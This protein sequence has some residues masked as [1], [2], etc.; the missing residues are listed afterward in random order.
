MLVKTLSGLFA[1]SICLAQ[2]DPALS[3]GP[4]HN[5]Q[6]P[7]SIEVLVELPNNG[8]AEAQEFQLIEDG[9]LTSRGASA[10]PFRNS[11]WKLALVLALDVSRSL[12]TKEFDEVK[13]ATI[14]FITQ[15]KDPVALISFGD[16]ADTLATFDTP[17]ESLTGV[18]SQLHPIGNRTRLY[19]ALDTCM[20]QLENRP[21]PERQRIIVISDGAEDSRAGPDSID[22]VIAKAEKHRVAIDTIWVPTAAAGARNTL[23]RISERTDGYHVDALQSQQILH[24]LRQVLGRVDNSMI[25][26]FDRKID[27][28]ALTKEVGVGID[29]AGIASASIALQIPASAMK[30]SWYERFQSFV[31][32]IGGAQALLGVLGAVAAL[33]VLYLACFVLVK[34]YYAQYVLLFPWD[35]MRLFKRSQAP[36]PVPVIGPN[37]LVSP[38][39]KAGRK[40]VVEHPSEST[41]VRGLVL[42]AVNGP[43][44]GRRIPIES[45]RFRIGADPDSDLRIPQDDYVSGRHAIIQASKDGWLLID[46]DSRNGTYIDGKK[47]ETG[48]NRVLSSGQKIQIGT[49]EFI[50]SLGHDAGAAHI[51]ASSEPVR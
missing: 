11:K 7:G 40:T 23:V 19:D 26:A 43:L 14:D 21:P 36:T 24:G 34:K 30:R 10:S 29:R 51:G 46:D 17:R 47:I 31:G 48:F 18:I 32:F 12:T 39:R 22:T 6:K 38:V 3:L 20:R 25:V 13:K 9:H 5:L 33:F 16:S 15:I 50:V 27:S 1:V 49:S 8:T 28:S 2:S 35:P 45:Q 44:I 41:P 4:F 42:D 37:R